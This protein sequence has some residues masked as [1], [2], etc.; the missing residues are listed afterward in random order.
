[1]H[2]MVGYE[3]ADDGF[4]PPRYYRI[5]AALDDSPAAGLAFRHAVGI[6]REQHA[7]LTLLTVVPTP[8]SR[9][10]AAGIAPSE[11][12]AEMQAQ[13]DARLRALAAGAPG[14]LSLTTIVRQGDPAAE[15]LAVLSDGLFDLLCM[16]ARGRG[17]LATAVLG[18]VSAAV[19]HS[20]PTPVMVLHPAPRTVG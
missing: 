13:A 15:I 8:S 1:M 14:D 16:G 6:A 4:E 17:W 11:L 5:L 7:P 12:L 19:L 18:S 2:T 3:H 10:A 20:S 9:V